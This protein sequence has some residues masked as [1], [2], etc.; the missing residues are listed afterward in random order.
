M[1]PIRLTSRRNKE[2][3]GSG[4]VSQIMDGEA[5]NKTLLFYP[6][7]RAR[8]HRRRYR[9]ASTVAALGAAAS[10]AV[11]PTDNGGHLQI[12]IGK[13]DIVRL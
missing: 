9:T 11:R 7:S 6:R 12:N 1:G 4:G 10:A 8:R 3:H 2:S 5:I 13:I